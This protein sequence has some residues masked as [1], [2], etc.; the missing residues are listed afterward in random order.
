L[1]EARAIEPDIKQF[2]GLRIQDV[3]AA[4]TETARPARDIRAPF[5]LC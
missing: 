4:S 5:D 2:E 3:P 1:H